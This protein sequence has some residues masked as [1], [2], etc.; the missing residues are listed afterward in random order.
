MPAQL[1][2][3]KVRT[4]GRQSIYV[5]ATNSGAAHIKITISNEDTSIPID[6]SPK[7]CHHI[8]DFLTRELE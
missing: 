4:I 3:D 8:K 2:I 1:R 5:E 6:L 7:D